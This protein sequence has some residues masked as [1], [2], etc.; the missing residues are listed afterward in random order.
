[1][2]QDARF[3]H[4]WI[5]IIGSYKCSSCRGKFEGVGF[6]H[7]RL[8]V[9]RCPGCTPLQHAAPLKKHCSH[10]TQ[11]NVHGSSDLCM[12]MAEHPAVVLDE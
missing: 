6:V 2:R 11:F 12:L 5:A 4:P 1:M 3:Y 9:T 10:E 8:P 7:H